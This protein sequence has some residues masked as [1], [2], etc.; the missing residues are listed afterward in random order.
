MH[1]TLRTQTDYGVLAAC[2]YKL[3]TVRNRNLLKMKGG[4]I[5]VLRG[6]SVA[7]TTFF[8]LLY[9]FLMGGLRS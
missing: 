7:N 8:R 1:F 9:G 2:I 3:L 6:N 5:E 4:V